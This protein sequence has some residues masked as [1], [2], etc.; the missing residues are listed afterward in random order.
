MV[1]YPGLARHLCLPARAQV[2]VRQVQAGQ[3]GYHYG[4]ELPYHY[5][6]LGYYASQNETQASHPPPSTRRLAPRTRSQVC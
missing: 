3:A 4:R 1:A 2:Q 6:P 5:A